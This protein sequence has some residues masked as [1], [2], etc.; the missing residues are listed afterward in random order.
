MLVECVNVNSV[1]LFARA[2]YDVISRGV[3]VR[4]RLGLQELIAQFAGICKLVVKCSPYRALYK[5]TI[6]NELQWK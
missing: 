4:V 2:V 5:L 3:L 1:H 6:K